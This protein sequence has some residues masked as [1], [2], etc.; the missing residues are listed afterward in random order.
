[1]I[2]AL[3]TELRNLNV[4][5]IGLDMANGISWAL[6]DLAAIAAGVTLIPLPSFFTPAQIDHVINTADIG[7]I[8]CADDQ[9][10]RWKAI[11]TWAKLAHT[12]FGIHLFKREG[13]P[14]A[15]GLGGK[16]T[17]T[18]GSSGQPKGVLLSAGTIAATSIGIVEALA[19]LG[20]RQ[21]LCV[22]PLATLLENVA[23]LYAPLINGSEVC[24]PSDAEIGLSGAAL[25]IERF[26][27]LLNASQADTMILV[28]QLLTAVVTL[29]ELGALNMST[30]KLIAVGGG[31]VGRS[32]H[33]RAQALGLP[34]FEGYGLSECCSVLTLNL[35]G[36]ERIGS[37]GRLLNHTALR[38]SDAGEIQV[39]TPQMEGYIGEEATKPGWYA[40]GD[41]GHLDNDGYLYIDG[42]ARNVFITAFGR[43]VNPEWPE[44]ALTQHA[45]IGQALVYGEA[46]DHNLGL[47]WLRFAQT[48]EQIAA[49]MSAANAE[50]PDYAQ[51]HQWLVISEN[52]PGEL[53]TANG[54]LKRDAAIAYYGE[55]IE[56][57]YHNEKAGVDT[58]HPAFQT[59]IQTPDE[60][61]RNV[62]L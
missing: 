54:R 55:L 31:R 26:A 59:N 32:L 61:N 49:L 4:A 17:F 30:F 48:D 11:D 28:P 19:P 24:L 53:Q 22:L 34:V 39:K 2:A 25:D 35:P 43:N 38:I 21:H 10:S 18:S 50:L 5:R 7:V 47:L 33:E 16:I 58:C 40:T 45:A 42:R 13:A 20:P 8:L 12:P 29:M 15:T 27:A 37:V 36:A 46:Q 60:R 23:G 52:L 14:V 57:H 6:V 1:D 62:I 51:I 44:A 56:S 3:A 9:L 41:L